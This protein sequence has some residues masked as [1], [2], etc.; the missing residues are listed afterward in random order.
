MCVTLMSTLFMALLPLLALTILGGLVIVGIRALRGSPAGHS[1]QTRDQE[2]WLI[3]EIYQGLSKMEKRIESLE[4]ILLH[5]E[6]MDRNE[7]DMSR[8]RAR[9]IPIT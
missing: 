1:K 9:N 4:T 3:Q 2:A 5:D 7:R 8:D 6:R